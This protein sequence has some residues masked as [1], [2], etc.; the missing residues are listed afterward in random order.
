M[1]VQKDGE[2]IRRMFASIAPR[3]DLLNHVLSLNVDRSW[4]RRTVRE[5]NLDASA[6]VLDVC[7]GTA[8]LALELTRAVRPADGGL[9]VGSDFTAEMVKLGAEKIGGEKRRRSCGDRPN[10]CVADTLALPFPDAAFDA[11]TVG[12][13]VRNLADLRAGLVEMLRVLK[14]HGQVAILEFSTPRSP[15]FRGLYKFYFRRLLPKLGSWISRT[16]CGKSAYEYLPASVAEFPSAPALSDLMKS[17]G[18]EDVRYHTL[19]FGIT[20]LH[21]ACRP[22]ASTAADDLETGTRTIAPVESDTQ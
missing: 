18:Y 1:R 2:R 10:L 16:E 13:G 22:P 14:P 12:F 9:V 4:R 20:T 15:A 17:C 5:L 7:T 6:R 11:V 3:Y 8:D 19:T 21:L